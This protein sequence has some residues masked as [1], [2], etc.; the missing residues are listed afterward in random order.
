M[1][2]PHEPA[3]LEAKAQTHADDSFRVIVSYDRVAFV[4]KPSRENLVGSARR[5]RSKRANLVSTSELLSI[6]CHGHSF[7]LASYEVD[8][9]WARPRWGRFLGANACVL[10]FENEHEEH[11]VQPTDVLERLCSLNL[12]PLIMYHAF[13]SKP[14]YDGCH[15]LAAFRGRPSLVYHP[16]FRVV[17]RLAETVTDAAEAQKAIRALY[18]R[19]PEA[20]QRCRDVD[21]IFLGSRSYGYDFTNTDWDSYDFE[22][23]AVS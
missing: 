21:R 4:V 7:A 6:A 17:V 2:H 13:G 16:R 18:A 3:D 15:G 20:D 5:V 22:R 12:D 23:A 8:P 19:F 14:G 10:A 11:Y 9:Y 1:S